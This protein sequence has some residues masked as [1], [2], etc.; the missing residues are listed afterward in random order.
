MLEG[1]IEKLGLTENQAKVYLALVEEGPALVS[2]IG[3]KSDLNRTTCYDVLEKLVGY[4][5]ASYASGDGSKKK[6]VAES[7]ET[8]VTYLERKKRTYQNRL[9]DLKDKLP[10]LMALYKRT[11]KPVIK[12]LE[13]TEAIRASITLNTDNEDIL[14]ESQRPEVLTIADLEAW[15]APDLARSAKKYLKQLAKHKYPERMLIVPTKKSLAWINDYPIP[16]KKKIEIRFL[17]EGRF[18]L[19][20]T[21]VNII[22][23]QVW[24]TLLEKPDRMV[25]EIASRQLADTLRILFEMAWEA[26]EKYTPK[27]FKY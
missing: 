17:P 3:Q 8:L 15:D 24:F 1:L 12:F 13:G 6:Y 11:D 14:P 22:G 16:I 20:A 25:M 26:A 2:E 4:G 7:P 18:P 23:N 21:E 19:F 27:N 9:E 10:E 5:L